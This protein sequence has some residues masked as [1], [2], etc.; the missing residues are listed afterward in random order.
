ME[1]WKRVML[2]WG[3]GVHGV[4]FSEVVS[5]RSCCW[6]AERCVVRRVARLRSRSVFVFGAMFGSI[7]VGCW[8]S[9]LLND[10]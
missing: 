2:K 9:R 4:K 3:C 8:S 5:S 6:A 10:F 1:A 7:G